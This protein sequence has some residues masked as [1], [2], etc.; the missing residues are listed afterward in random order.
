M[1]KMKGVAMDIER[2]KEWMGFSKFLLGTVILGLVATGINY[3]FQ[4]REIE[5]KEMEQLG[6]Y[7]AHAIDENLAVQERFAVYFATMTTSDELRKRWHEYQGIIDTKIEQEEAKL[8]A[9]KEEAREEQAK[10]SL[11]ESRLGEQQE[12]IERLKNQKEASS[13]SQRRQ[14]IEKALISKKEEINSIVSERF[15]AED[16]LAIAQS[17]IYSS[18]EQLTYKRKSDKPS[19]AVKTGWLYLGQYNI[20]TKQWSKTNLEI[21]RGIDPQALVGTTIR[22]IVESINIRSGMPTPKGQFL[23]VTDVINSGDPVEITEVKEWRDTGYMWA[24][25]TYSPAIELRYITYYNTGFKEG[26][27]EFD[28]R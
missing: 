22:V 23:K 9:K 4:K 24:Q 20:D 17:D 18:M 14:E 10:I 11:L 28:I 26:S 1:S 25:V 13:D 27:H 8:A 21:N 2:F 12:E 7:V 5:I 15:E 19:R 6:K 16:N 3:H